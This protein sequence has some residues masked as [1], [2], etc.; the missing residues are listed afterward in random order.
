MQISVAQS[1][2]GA[3]KTAFTYPLSIDNKARW[4]AAHG[5][6][7]VVRPARVSPPRAQSCE[8]GQGTGQGAGDAPGG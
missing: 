7:L 4:A 8:A 6:T 2:Y 5:Y 1:E 3:L